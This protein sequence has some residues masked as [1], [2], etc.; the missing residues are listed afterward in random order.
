MRDN[1]GGMKKGVGSG[2]NYNPQVAALL[3]DRWPVIPRRVSIPRNDGKAAA[4]PCTKVVLI[5]LCLR[6]DSSQDANA[7]SHRRSYAV[8]PI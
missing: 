1:L 7:S 4:V 5:R 6:L 8:N 2:E 3:M